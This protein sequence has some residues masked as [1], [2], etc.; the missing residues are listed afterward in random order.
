[1]KLTR[2]QLKN[3]IN[4]TVNEARYLDQTAARAGQTGAFA[5]GMLGTLPA[6]VAMATAPAGAYLGEKIGTMIANYRGHKS[7]PVA[8]NDPLHPANLF[9]I[10][11][12]AKF[13]A[14]RVEEYIRENNGFKN[15]IVYS[16]GDF[17]MLENPDTALLVAIIE[18]LGLAEP[19]PMIAKVINF[20]SKIPVV[21]P[22]IT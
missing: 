3:L 15:K 2:R 22:F 20:V 1:M 18:K 8:E 5:G 11:E 12:A 4:E 6:P 17:D 19:S 10:A 9:E 7:G 21:G 14:Q 13:D 16:V